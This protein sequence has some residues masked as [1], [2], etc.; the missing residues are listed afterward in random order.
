MAIVDG[1][2]QLRRISVKQNVGAGG[3][4]AGLVKQ[5]KPTPGPGDA[6][7]SHTGN[8]P[9]ESVPGHTAA[10]SGTAEADTP[11]GV[12]PEWVWKDIAVEDYSPY[13]EQMHRAKQQAA[14]AGLEAAYLQ[15]M[16]AI[17]RAEAGAAQEHR[18]ARNQAV[19]AAELAKRN[20][21]QYAAASGLNSGTGGQAELAR[22]MVLQGNLGVIN[23]READVMAELELK[24]AEA[25]TEYNAA[26]AQA[27]YTG[28]YDLAAA[29][30]EEKVRVQEALT[31]QA[32]RRQKNE[33]EQ[34]QLRYQAQRDAVADR[35][36]ERQ[37]ALKEQTL[38]E[39]TAETAPVKMTLATAKE[40]AKNGLLS[41]AVI[42]VLNANGYD[43]AAIKTLYGDAASGA[44]SAAGPASI[45]QASLDLLA[46][47][48]P[49]GVISDPLRWQYWADRY[50][51]AALKAAGYRRGEQWDLPS[52]VYEAL[53]MGHPEKAVARIDAMWDTLTEQQREETLKILAGYGYKYTPA[54]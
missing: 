14:A 2:D 41:D 7:L 32:I 4:N 21:N 34:Y 11:T 1:K 8:G 22:N 18:A 45:P 29:L 46:A 43:D 10:P 47:S 44:L 16:A 42:A 50:G 49:D 54:S 15:N 53:G 38:K 27:G 12:R 9:I 23:A 48:F 40:L 30:Y 24:R 17:D 13:L 51:E 33:L 39:Q 20:F 3:I 26:I 35:R 28:E 19:G 25:E 31:E 37:Q 36:Y 5:G 52:S 6:A